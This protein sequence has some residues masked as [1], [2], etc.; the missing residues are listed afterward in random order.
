MAEETKTNEPV[1]TEQPQIEIKQEPAEEKK[2]Q[3]PKKV[4][5]EKQ[6][7]ALKKGRERRW[8]KEVSVKVQS[9]VE[10]Q[11]SAASSESEEE[12]PPPPPKL[13]REKK[14]LKEKKIQLQRNPNFQTAISA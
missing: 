9:E 7:E 8:K 6:R 11:L 10:T 1:T 12:L 5:S 4:I 3:K 13:K 2:P 14:I